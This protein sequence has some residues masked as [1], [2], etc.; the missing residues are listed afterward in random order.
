MVG[1]SLLVGKM[2]QSGS[3]GMVVA[4]LFIV[5]ASLIL[6]RRFEAPDMVLCSL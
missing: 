5:N 6:V 4:V 2:V 1:N 3:Q